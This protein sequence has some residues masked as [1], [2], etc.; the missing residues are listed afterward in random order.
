MVPV[1]SRKHRPADQRCTPS[2]SLFRYLPSSADDI[3]SPLRP[4][5][6]QRL[7]K[8]IKSTFISRGDFPLS[9]KAKDVRSV[10]S[11]HVSNLGCPLHAVA[12][13]LR[14]GRWKRQSTFRS[15]YLRPLVV[16]EHDPAKFKTMPISSILRVRASRLRGV[17]RQESA[18]Y[19]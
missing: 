10:A 4:L 18:R 11:P 16:A 1:P 13:V 5:G 6:K 2:P 14:Q 19:S 12:R 3:S 17:P 8:I 9:F 15:H 7:A